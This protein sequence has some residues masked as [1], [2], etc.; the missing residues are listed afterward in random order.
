LGISFA[1]PSRF[2]VSTKKGGKDS[3]NIIIQ[4]SHQTVDTREIDTVTYKFRSDADLTI[5]YSWDRFDRIAD[6]AGFGKNERMDDTT[7]LDQSERDAL[8]L[9]TSRGR[10][11]MEE[12]VSVLSYDGWRG[13]YGINFTGTYGEADHGMTTGYQGLH[14]FYAALARKKL[15]RGKCVS[16]SFSSDTGEDGYV[17][18]SVLSTFRF[19]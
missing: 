11:G 7:D 2:S 5:E 9:W 13:F 6:E 17:F 4:L 10:Q 12:D 14:E 18:Q 8:P 15:S 19:E 3:A 16:I 1:Y